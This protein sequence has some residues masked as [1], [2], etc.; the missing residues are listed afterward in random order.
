MSNFRKVVTMYNQACKKRAD[1][2]RLP[3]GFWT[4]AT[5]EV[6]YFW[7]SKDGLCRL[8]PNPPEK[9]GEKEWFK[10]ERYVGRGAVFR[11]SRAHPAGRRDPARVLAVARCQMSQ[12][13][14][15]SVSW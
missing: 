12:P 7:Y 5:D 4:D 13:G 3:N 6:L 2:R 14:R 11:P 15:S 10:L 9:V 1:W 8:N